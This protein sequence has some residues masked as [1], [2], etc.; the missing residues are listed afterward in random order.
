MLARIYQ[1]EV[2]KVQ[3]FDFKGLPDLMAK[4]LSAK[5]LIEHRDAQG[6]QLVRA[7]RRMSWRQFILA[8]GL[9]TAKEMQTARFGAY[10]ADGARQIPNKGDLRD[11]WI[12]ISS[13]KAFLGIAPSYTAI[14]D[15]IFRLFY[16]LIACSIAGRVRHLR[17]YLRLFAAGRKS[18]DH[19]SRGQFIARLAKYF[20][21]LTVKILQGLTVIALEL[22]IIDMSELMRLQI[23]EQ[24]DDTWAWVAKG[25]ERQPDATVGAF[26][27]A[28]DAPVIDEG[29]RLIRHPYRHHHHQLLPGLCHRG[30]P[31]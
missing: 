19:I 26:R 6:F 7:R 23:C 4:R 31:D 16:R 25:P 10:W 21:L 29:A 2:H 20:G 9:H 24:F 5:M 15:L 1:R 18:G 30:W 22:L 28:Q 17:R 14:Q 8:L 11:Y 12:G 27:V 13:T 3:V